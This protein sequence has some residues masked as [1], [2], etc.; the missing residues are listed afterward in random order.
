MNAIN[1]PNLSTPRILILGGGFAGL[2]FARAINTM[3]Y[4]VVL[5]DQNN[6]HT[7]QPLLHQVATAGLEPDS[8]AYPLRK[9]LKIKART[10]IRMS[11]VEKVDLDKKKVQTSIGEIEYDYLVIA[12]G[13]E[14]NYFGNSNIRK[15][16]VPMKSLK[17]SLDLRSLILQNFESSLSQLDPT[18][19]DSLMNFVIVGGGPTGVQLADALAELKKHV[20]PKDYLDYQ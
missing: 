4:Q 5:I 10:H 8:I 19:S 2:K 9:T 1:I 17:E 14:T 15:Y 11:K 6:Y 18:E 3:H 16:A 7:F 12:T 20:R 13:A